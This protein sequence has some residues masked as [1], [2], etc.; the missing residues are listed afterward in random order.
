MDGDETAS[1]STTTPLVL[2]PLCPVV[3]VVPDSSRSV[4]VVVV[5]SL[6]RRRMAK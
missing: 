4:L 5:I 3:D 2:L 1:N 6:R